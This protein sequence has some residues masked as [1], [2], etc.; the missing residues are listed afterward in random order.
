[1]RLTFVAL[2]VAA[3]AS[4]ASAS[5][6]WN[7]KANTPGPN[8]GSGGMRQPTQSTGFSGRIRQGTLHI[9]ALDEQIYKDMST[10]WDQLRTIQ[11]SINLYLPGIEEDDREIAY[12]NIKQK[13]TTVT[14]LVRHISLENKET[15]DILL[16]S[17]IEAQLIAFYAKY[18]LVKLNF[19]VV[20]FL[21]TLSR[22]H[23]PAF[24][25]GVRKYGG[26]AV[27]GAKTVGGKTVEGAQ[28]VGGKTITG[29]KAVR[30][31]GKTIYQKIQEWSEALKT[32]GFSVLQG[33]AGLEQADYDELVE[34]TDEQYEGLQHE[35]QS[36]VYHAQ[37]L[38][39][40]K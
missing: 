16:K 24:K 31:Q 10:C 27:A 12:E 11:W 6:L 13:L 7:R 35:E 22:K 14:E 34:E 30:R 3:L 33:W 4:S 18:N 37:Q 20:S 25:R 40:D 1:M 17:L 32:K 23:I 28:F 29:F 19:G 15:K 21:T 39:S 2:A 8:T 36:F 9:A 5:F 26:K 38:H